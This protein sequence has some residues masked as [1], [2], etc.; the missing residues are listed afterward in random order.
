MLRAAG[1]LIDQTRAEGSSCAD[2]TAIRALLA[3]IFPGT[4][5]QDAHEAL[6]RLVEALHS[7]CGRSGA[8][9]DARL[10][11]RDAMEA[12][13]CR[14]EERDSSIV[15]DELR[16]QLESEVSCDACGHVSRA[17]EAFWEL[18]VSPRGHGR[19]EECVR[20]FFAREHLGRDY[21]CDGCGQRGTCSRRMSVRRAPLTLVVCLTRFC[22]ASMQKLEDALL[23]PEHTSLGGRQYELCAV[24]DHAGTLAGG[25]Y[26]ARRRG[27]CGGSSSAPW[28]TCNDSF[29]S[30]CPPPCGAPSASAYVLV[31]T[32]A[33]A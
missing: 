8:D 27:E 16:G 24:I 17:F 22:G 33:T 5:Q 2:A 28:V 4:R 32:D 3:P 12:A 25:H 14:T 6:M 29:V 11:A 23:L 10:G 31:Y 20:T 15:S 18:F 30:P 7:D 13:R 21:R 19:L 26:T 9:V 1:A